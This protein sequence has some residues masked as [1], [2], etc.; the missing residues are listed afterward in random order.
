MHYI[1]YGNDSFDKKRFIKKL[2]IENPKSQVVE[3]DC[4]SKKFSYQSIVTEYSMLDLFSSPKII[5][6]NDFQDFKKTKKIEE[7]EEIHFQKILDSDIDNP[8]SIVFT[9]DYSVYKQKKLFKIFEKHNIFLKEFKSLDEKK[10]SAY[11]RTRI[12]KENIKIN[13]NAFNQLLIRINSDKYVLENEISKF[14]SYG[15]II[16]LNVVEKLVSKSYDDN[17]FHLINSIIAHDTKSALKSLG[18]LYTLNVDPNMIIGLLASQYRFLFQVKALATK[19]YSNDKIASEIG[20]KKSGRI[21]YAQKS[22]SRVTTTYLLHCLHDLSELEHRFKTINLINR[23]LELE[24][25]ILN[26]L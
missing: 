6:A 2:L 8:N 15:G 12:R 7:Q 17:T 10:F 20:L 9:C 5:I 18:D 19:G 3:I 21:Y 14:K 22:I 24:L 23:N 16:D 13:E 11:A 25:F 4:N 1:L 26:K